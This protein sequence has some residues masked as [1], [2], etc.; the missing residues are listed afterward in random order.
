MVNKILN[1]FIGYKDSEKIRALCIF[2]PQMIVYKKNFMKIDVFFNKE[3]K[4]FIRCMEILEKVCNTIKSKYNSALIYSRKYLKAEKNKH[5]R[6]L[7][8]V[9]FTNNID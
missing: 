1:I 9:I 8:M 2:R 5:K 7:S 4:I 3:E 6:K